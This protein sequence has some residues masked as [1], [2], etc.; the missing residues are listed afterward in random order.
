MASLQ[1][2]V[3]KE[4]GARFDLQ[5]I[6]VTDDGPRGGASSCLAPRLTRFSRCGPPCRRCRRDRATISAPDSH[7]GDGGQ[8]H[9]GGD[10]EQARARGLV[11]AAGSLPAEGLV[12]VRLAGQQADE[13][14]QPADHDLSAPH[15]RHALDL[16]PAVTQSTTKALRREVDEV[17]R[18]VEVQPLVAEGLRLHAAL[19]G[20]AMTTTPPGRSRRAAWR[21]ASPGL[22]RCSS[23]CQKTTAAHSPLTSSSGSSLRSSRVGF[24]SRPVASRPSARRASIETCPSPAPTSSTGPAGAI[25]SIRAACR[26]RSAAEDGVGAEVEAPLRV[27]SVPV[28]VG[29]RRARRRWGAGRWWP[30]HSPRTACA[31]QDVIGPL[32]EGSAAPDAGGRRRPCRSG[33]PLGSLADRADVERLEEI[34]VAQLEVAD[35]DR[36]GS[37]VGLVAVAEQHGVVEPLLGADGHVP[38]QA[39]GVLGEEA[40]ELARAPR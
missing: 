35:L 17:A 23:E 27:G 30:R 1:E 5:T 28:A 2:W 21:M 18:H 3:L 14:L 32:V 9:A 31:V 19:F 12:Q 40:V 11:D 36:L 7:R 37:R 15:E 20:T 8:H 38:T 29:R 26:P 10:G 4:I 6:V 13:A 39:Q 34:R 25:S 33:S 22:G 24:R 16:E